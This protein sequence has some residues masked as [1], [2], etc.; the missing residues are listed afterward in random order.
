MKYSVIIPTY[1]H[2]NDCLRPCIESLIKTTTLRPGEIEIIIVANGCVD[3]TEQYVSALQ[4]RYSNDIFKLLTFPAPLGYTRAT[5]EGLKVAKGEFIVLLNNDVVLLDWQAPDDWLNILVKPFLEDPLVAITGTN[6]LQRPE[7]LGSK[8]FLVFSTVMIKREIIQKFGLLDEVFSPGSGED[9]DYCMKVILG[10][11]KIVEVPEER[12]TWTYT[13]SFPIYHA[14]EK[15]V[16]DLPQWDDIYNRNMQIIKDRYFDKMK[17]SIIIPT[18]NHLEDC[19]K[20]CLQSVIENTNFK[21][22]DTE[23][24]VVANGCS[25]GTEDFVRSL[26]H[27][28]V[29]LLSFSEPLGYGRAVNE[30][31]N[32]SKGQFVV[33]LNNDVVIYPRYPNNWLDLLVTPFLNDDSVG[34]TGPILTTS[35]PAQ[36]EFIVF[37][38]VM[39]KRQVFD[40]V[41]LL[42]ETFYPGA[43]EDTDFCVKARY[44]GYKLV[45]VPEPGTLQRSDSEPGVLVGGFP[46]YHK[47]EATVHGLPQWDESFKRNSQILKERYNLTYLQQKYG[48]QYERPVIPRFIRPPTREHEKYKWGSDQVLPGESI[49]ELGCGSGYGCMYFIEKGCTYLGVDIDG[50]IIE[51]ARAN[52]PE[53][54]F[55]QAD[56]TKTFIWENVSVDTIVCFDTIEH[57]E[58]GVEFLNSLKKSCSKLLVSVPYREPYGFWGFH[59]K[60]HG[61]GEEHFPDFDYY[62]MNE[63][64]LISNVP[65]K[66]PSRVYPQGIFNIML[67]KWEKGKTYRKIYHCSSC[68][69]EIYELFE[70]KPVCSKCRDK[71]IIFSTRFPE[72]SKKEEQE[73]MPTILEEQPSNDDTSSE[74][75]NEESQIEESQHNI[76]TIQPASSKPHVLCCISTKDRYF[77]TLPMTL[78]SIAN[79]TV[80]PD[81]LVI[82]DDG[83]Q[84]DLRENSTYQNIF[85]LISQKGIKWSVFFTPRLGQHHNHQKSQEMAKDLVWRIDDDEIAEP[86]TL[87]ILLS[88]FIEDSDQKKIGA[89][90]GLV[91]PT[92]ANVSPRSNI[93]SFN[94]IKDIYWA[95]NIQWYKHERDPTSGRFPVF[96]VEHLYSSFLYRAK[97]VDYCLDLSQVAHREET[98]FTYSMYRKGYKLLVDSEAIT[99]HLREEQGGIRSGTR[100][101]M[102]NHDEG[103]F[104]SF[105]KQWNIVPVPPKFI[106][107]DNGIG[108]H[109][110]FRTIFPEVRSAFPDRK[111]VMAVCYP[112]VFEDVVEEDGNVVLISIADAKELLGP[113]QVDRMNIYRFADERNWKSSLIDA[114]RELYLKATI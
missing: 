1:N 100:A 29:K 42:D 82:F 109:Y 65:W 38:C 69:E 49:L 73:N 80:P 32:V 89:V 67:M 61:L 58:N 72:T 11:Y 51:F 110:M 96:Y 35:E 39:I 12:D 48:N 45:Q 84:K 19:L 50:N 113:D 26:N 57:L 20:P 112:D 5:N 87:E 21:N 53:A 97:I 40:Q 94:E 85:S 98:I 91:L 63:D 74:I 18:Y 34:I 13:T 6:K 9:I 70:G 60:L 46:I 78:I 10:G 88:H 15:T 62:Y 102:W 103:I 47:G 90:A 114:Y 106:V 107:L 93:L 56:I 41:G 25:D 2:L 86:K 111:I 76:E 44:Y 24:I 55:M 83:E 105:L 3:G 71:A 23:I 17:Y 77:T 59:H 14:A 66:I 37:F 75:K 54:M 79:Q 52:Y 8:K 30:G 64:G 22:G 81:E 43:G 95:P 99:W 68:L 108:D 31:I 101:E 36:Q 16:F 4:E 7:F 104:A 33:L 28:Y 92:K 27:P